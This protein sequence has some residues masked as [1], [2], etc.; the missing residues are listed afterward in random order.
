VTSYNLCMQQGTCN[1]R[2]KEM[3]K[4][5]NKSSLPVGLQKYSLPA[6]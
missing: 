6:T 2:T 1:R 3:N 4:E 5:R